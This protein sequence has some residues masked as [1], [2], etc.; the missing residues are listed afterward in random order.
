VAFSSA[1]STAAKHRQ[2]RMRAW[3]ARN[4][5]ETECRS[6]TGLAYCVVSLITQETV[7]ER[8]PPP[9]PRLHRGGV[10]C[11]AAQITI[12]KLGENDSTAYIDLRHE[13]A[14]LHPEQLDAC[15]SFQN[16]EGA[17]DGRQSQR[18]VAFGRTTHFRD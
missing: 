11:A 17:A 15:H 1:E 18:S 3:R 5:T 8:A 6:C 16:C 10:M 9:E 13:L 2:Q 7:N 14:N 12:K 4:L